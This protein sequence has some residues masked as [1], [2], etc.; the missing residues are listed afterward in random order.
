MSGI[1]YEHHTL[2]S[3]FGSICPFKVEFDMAEPDSMANWHKNPEIIY[4][5]DGEGSVQC[6]SQSYNARKGDIFVINTETIHNVLSSGN[7][8]YYFIIIDEE[9]CRDNGIELESYRFE[10][11][12]SDKEAERTAA[13]II[14]IYQKRDTDNPMLC[15]AKLRCAVMEMLVGLCE[16]HAEYIP[17]KKTIGN[18]DIY[19]RKAIVFISE[20][21]NRQLTADEIASN[22][23]ITKFHLV[24]EFKKYTGETVIS[25]LNKVRCT[26][27]RQM[28]LGGYTVTQ[29]AIECG[30][31]SVSY[32][33]Q[34]FKRI[35][36]ISP[37]EY[38]RNIRK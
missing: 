5:T 38:I 16:H 2:K 15:A 36:G 17:E 32:F 25:H 20:N 29:A 31:E 37:R 30:F 8:G 22:I 14:D 10:P 26:K 1:K 21:Y 13:R 6:G 19:V 33:S 3:V 12:V 35:M 24:R 34:K 7:M 27:A 4:I 18:S 11:L 9:F 23:G 28:I